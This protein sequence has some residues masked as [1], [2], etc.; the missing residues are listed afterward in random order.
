MT[1]WSSLA[2]ASTRR[3]VLRISRMINGPLRQWLDW[4]ER[5]TFACAHPIVPKLSPMHRRPL[6][7]KTA[8]SPRHPTGQNLE[9]FDVDRRLVLPVAGVE[10]GSPQVSILVVIH[11]DRDAVEAAY[12]W[13]DRSLRQEKSQNVGITC[14]T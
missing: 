10:V 11:P 9:A 13:H 1:R 8:R 6:G 7:D 3:G 5:P 14:L 12:S 4:R 2:F